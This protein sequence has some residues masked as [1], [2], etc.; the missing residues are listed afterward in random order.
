M[1]TIYKTNGNIP[2]IK[3]N[4]FGNL[5]ILRLDLTEQE[6][7]N[8]RYLHNNNVEQYD[9]SSRHNINLKK[10]G[11]ISRDFSNNRP[12]GQL[13]EAFF[14]I[15]SNY[16]N[17]FQIYFYMLSRHFISNNFRSYAII[18]KERTMKRLTEKIKDDDIDILIDMQGHMH[19]NFTQ[20]LLKKP[21]PIQI[22]WLGYPGT[23]GISTIDYLI[24][25]EIIIP[26]ESQRY[27]TEKIAYMPH[28][29]Q[30]NNKKLLSNMSTLRRSDY[31]IPENA[32]VFCHFNSDYK[33][34]RQMW[35]IWLSILK[36]IKN[37]V[38][39]YSTSR[40][41]FNTMLLD[42]AKNNGVD[43]KQ[44]IR[45]KRENRI[46]HINRLGLF[47][48]GLD[49]YRVNGH[50]TSSD[51]IAGGIPF[52]T[53]TSETYHNRVAK[54]ILYSL[55]LKEL[56]CYSFDEYINL[57]VKL[58]TDNEYYSFVKNKVLDNRDKYL[59]NTSLYVGNFVNLMYNIWKNHYDHDSKYIW[60]YYPDLDSPDNNI[61]SSYHSDNIHDNAI[62]T[63][64]CIAYNTKGELKD[65][66]NTL[67]AGCGIWIKE[68]LKEDNISHFSNK[69]TGI[70]THE[71]VYYPNKDS[72]DNNI[73]I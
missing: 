54:S 37:S 67:V 22:H 13:S 26:K 64:N 27:Y 55:D 41:T 62:Y 69:Y 14:D 25:D 60:R 3:Y 33:L 42:D 53:Y 65:K 19:D 50:T 23:T 12:S 36:L 46:T 63:A 48:L 8:Y 61:P 71:W 47:N 44:L 39:V 11:F 28:C 29:Y 73:Y 43:I 20:L 58:A 45:V 49:N 1:Y 51:L 59:Y 4:H 7:Y 38:L 32:F 72:P 16:K 21:A 24:A 66:L 70:K 30:C 68:E 10:I 6:I 17:Q 9:H 31:N 34:D 40:T 56:V 18:R 35:F 5:N 2:Y 57:A 15:L 52:I